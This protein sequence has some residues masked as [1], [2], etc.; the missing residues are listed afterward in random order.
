[1]SEGISGMMSGGAGARRPTNGRLSFRQ[2]AAQGQ[3]DGP[4]TGSSVNLDAGHHDAHSEKRKELYQEASDYLTSVVVS[5]RENKPF[6]IGSAIDI[7]EKVADIET[8]FDELFLKAIHSDDSHNF[9]VNHSVNLAIYAMK[10]AVKLGFSKTRQVEIGMLGLF[11]DVGMALISDD[12]VYKKERLSDSEFEQLKDRPNLGY[13]ILKQFED[14]YPFLAE[15]ALQVYEKIDGSGYPKGLMGEEINEYAQIVGLVDVYEALIHTRPQRQRLPHFF[16]VKEIIRTGKGKFK[17]VYLKALLNTFSIFPLLS[18][19]RLN[20]KAIGQVINTYSDQPMRP[21]I[22]VIYDS[23]KQRIL[24]DRVINLPENPLLYIT[25]SI[26]EEELFA[27]SETSELV[28]STGQA[29]AVLPENSDN[30]NEEGAGRRKGK[31]DKKRRWPFFRLGWTPIGLVAAL[32]VAA[33]LFAHY[34]TAVTD[35]TKS[36]DMVA[37]ASAYQHV[38]KVQRERIP[39]VS[40]A[41]LS[42]HPEN[43]LK[44]EVVDFSVTL[45]GNASDQFQS[46]EKVENRTARS[47]AIEIPETAD[48][49]AGLSLLTVP[50]RQSSAMTAPALQPKPLPSANAEWK[51]GFPFSIKFASHNNKMSAEKEVKALETAGIPAHWVKVNLGKDGIWY[52][53]FSGCFEDI[54]SAERYIA[55]RSI[56][57]VRVK[58]TGYSTLTGS[59]TDKAM[60]ER[61]L[62]EL[63]QKGFSPYLAEMEATF[64]VFVGA[65]Y[66]PEGAADQHS[67]LLVY[68]IENR[69]VQR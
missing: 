59:F 41:S 5:V 8:P 36:S 28:S 49:K 38:N 48:D 23:Q 2:L 58:K 3:K 32:F 34:G 47:V 57:G 11:H 54:D 64:H 50:T 25:D 22:R 4:A 10:M 31:R 17:Q 39:G 42:G 62:K 6:A 26:S 45:P 16:A 52:R 12:I 14:D 7:L 15:G 29:T 69:I 9:V 35:V 51:T 53:V 18:Y 40:P 46:I 44:K 20:S 68:G 24:T 33:A 21:K 13:E 66:T 43:Q 1:M 55:E 19:V 37:S 61:N 30:D 56:D 65:F 67:E 27:I 60:A 63:R